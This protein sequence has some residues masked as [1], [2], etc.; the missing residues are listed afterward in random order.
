[1]VRGDRRSARSRPCAAGTL[2]VAVAAG[3]GIEELHPDR[4]FAGGRGVASWSCV[5]WLVD[6][7]LAGPQIDDTF[8]V[9]RSHGS[10]S[11]CSVCL[12]AADRTSGEPLHR[13]HRAR[14]GDSFARAS[15]C[16]HAT[17]PRGRRPREIEGLQRLFVLPVASPSI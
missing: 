16:S 14:R 15:R 11:H 17:P 3:Y 6:R 9:F 13:R 5:E 10:R 4:A 1:M 12:P 7:D 8:G 2:A